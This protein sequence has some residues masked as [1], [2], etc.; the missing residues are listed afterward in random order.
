MTVD[1]GRNDGAPALL[2]VGRVNLDLYVEELRVAM[3]G[4]TSFRPSVGGSPTN[5]AIVAHRLTVQQHC[6]T[7]FPTLT[8]V[9]LQRLDH[10]R[11][12]TPS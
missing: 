6:S 2:T 7:G 9:G 12:L 5:I 10:P 8:D 4:A 3:A 11:E 1:H